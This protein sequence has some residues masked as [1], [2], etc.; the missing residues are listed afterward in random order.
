[1]HW[2]LNL[3]CRL[4]LHGHFSEREAWWTTPGAAFH[5][6]L[7]WKEIAGEDFEVLTPKTRE[8]WHKM[9][10]TDE[11]LEWRDGD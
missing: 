6:Q 10:W 7:C 3:A 8:E 4:M 2:V 11:L 9:G 5:Y 1:M